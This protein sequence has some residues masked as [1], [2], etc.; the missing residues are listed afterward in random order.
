MRGTDSTTLFLQARLEF[1]AAE[2]FAD[3]ARYALD[4]Y[5]NMMQRRDDTYLEALHLGVPMVVATEVAR[6]TTRKAEEEL[7]KGYVSTAA[8]KKHRARGEALMVKRDKQF[9][10]ELNVRFSG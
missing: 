5:E 4:L 7:E 3:E 9:R 2:A 10:R 1:K 6:E 8:S